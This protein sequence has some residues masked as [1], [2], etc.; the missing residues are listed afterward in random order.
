M[1]LSIAPIDP[2]ADEAFR[3][4][5]VGAS[6]VA[7]LFGMS[8]WLTEFE[9]WH[10]K[11]GNIATPDFNAVVDGVPENERVYW[12]VKMEPVIVEAACERWGYE[13][14]QSPHFLS[15]G[16]GLGGHPDRI[17][18]CPERGRGILEVKTAD[19]LVVKGWGDEPPAHYLLQNLTYQ[20]LAGCDWGDVIV[21]VGG[22]KLERFQYDIRPKIYADIEARVAAFW[23]SVRDGK[24]PKPDYSRDGRTLVDVIGA[25]TDEVIDLRNDFD[26]GDLAGQYLAAKEVEKAAVQRADTIKAQLIEKIGTAGFALLPDHKI[27]ATQT[28]G[29]PDRLITS[30]MVGEVIKGRRGYRR[31][32]VKGLA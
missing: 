4:A 3:A 21:L 14:L 29:T 5:H 10:R 11:A 24:A 32:D 17:V 31:F 9:L 6:E 27:S 30:D 20:G 19:W 8:P 7:A 23:Q 25:P 26:A 22:N 15:N 2:A 1:T 16:K 28:K 13:P 12:G 18:N